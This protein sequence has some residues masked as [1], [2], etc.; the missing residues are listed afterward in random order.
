MEK[1]DLLGVIAGFTVAILFT[2]HNGYVLRW[3]GNYQEKSLKWYGIWHR[4]SFW[5]RAIPFPILWYYQGLPLALS[6]SVVV[7][8]FYDFI[9]NLFIGKIHTNNQWSIR[10]LNL[11]MAKEAVIFTLK[12]GILILLFLSILFNWR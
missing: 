1:S 4:L 5:I 6:Y 3:G 9:E 12:L 7:W 10:K 8:V 11:A 2:L